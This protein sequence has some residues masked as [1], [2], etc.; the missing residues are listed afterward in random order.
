MALAV[1]AFRSDG[2]KRGRRLRQAALLAA[3]SLALEA[4]AG[5]L[6]LLTVDGPL[7]RGYRM[8]LRASVLSS[9][10]LIA[11][12]L[13]AGRAFAPARTPKDRQRGL[14]R[15]F[16]LVAVGYGFGMFSAIYFAI[17]YAN[18]P[19]SDVFTQ[20]LKNQ[21]FGALGVA[22]AA[23][24]AAS[25][26]RRTAQGVKPGWGLRDRERRLFRA[27]C[28]LAL[29]Y[30]IVCLGEALVAAGTTQIGYSGAAESTRWVGFVAGLVTVAAIA[31]AAIGFRR[32]GRG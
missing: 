8:A 2:E 3:V 10:G 22:V 32:A 23:A 5:L 6:T 17:A 14:G 18:Y 21:A 7:P 9:V 16:L 30:L 12:A 31:M 20:G 4:G 11:A 25:A 1:D 19:D 26:F 15:A 13:I 24:W 28:A 29:S 27:T